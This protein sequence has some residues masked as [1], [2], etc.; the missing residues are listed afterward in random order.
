MT[1]EESDSL[2]GGVTRQEVTSQRNTCVSCAAASGRSSNVES[3]GQVEGHFSC[4]VQ[5][6]TCQGLNS[7]EGVKNTLAK[8]KYM[9][10]LS[11]TPRLLKRA[12][13][14]ENLVIKLS[15]AS[16]FHLGYY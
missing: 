10:F 16:V 13:M 2:I 9:S 1:L 4:H 8:T 11:E 6:V 3:V 7:C 12:L 15:K 5:P 14:S